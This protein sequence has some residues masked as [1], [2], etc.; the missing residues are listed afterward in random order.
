MLLKDYF[1]KL[2]Q[3]ANFINKL[4]KPNNFVNKGPFILYQFLV[5]RTNTLTV[6][7]IAKDRIVT[8]R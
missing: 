6:L 2:Y 8:G 3:R 4:I 5:W 1:I 7:T